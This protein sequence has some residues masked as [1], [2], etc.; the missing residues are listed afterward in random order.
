[1]SGPTLQPLQVELSA[2]FLSGS[3]WAQGTENTDSL[4]RL[5]HA[6]LAVHLSDLT[7]EGD[8]HSGDLDYICKGLSYNF[9]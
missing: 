9:K 2:D 5:T 1:M 7:I 6:F 8:L 4:L 3:K